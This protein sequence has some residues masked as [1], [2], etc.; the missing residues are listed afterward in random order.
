ML[1]DYLID[2][3]EKLKYWQEVIST[4]KQSGKLP[5][6]FNISHFF[7]PNQFLYA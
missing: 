2:L 1:S 5:N 3:I 6:F 7:D 4:V